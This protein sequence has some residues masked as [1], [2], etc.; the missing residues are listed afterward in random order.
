MNNGFVPPSLAQHFEA[1]DNYLGHF[2]WICGYSAD[3]EFLNDAAERFTRQINAQRAFDGNISLVLLLDGGNPK[4]EI[5]DVP[6]VLHLAMKTPPTE[7]PFKL[8]HAKV[9]VLGFRHKSDKERWLLRLIVSTGNWTR[10]TLEESLDLAWCLNLDSTDLKNVNDKVLLACSDIVAAWDM[11][12]SVQKHFDLRLL[13]NWPEEHGKFLSGQSNNRFEAWITQISKIVKKEGS[14]PIPRFF[15]NRKKSLLDQ[16]PNMIDNTGNN[17]P[18]NYLAMGSGFYESSSPQQKPP[19]VISAIVSKLKEESA[20]RRLLTAGAEIDIFVNP[21]ACQGVS[22][23]LEAIQSNKWV[24]RAAAQPNYFGKNATRFLHAKFIFSA[25]N[26]QNAAQSSW[27]YLG[28]GN[29]TKQ[30]FTRKMSNSGGNLEAGV[31]FA[32]GKL[33]WKGTDIDPK[34]ILG[35]VIPVQR[36]SKIEGDNAL[37]AGGEMPEHETQFVVPPVAYFF[38]YENEGNQCSYLKYLVDDCLTDFNVIDESGAICPKIVDTEG[39]FFWLGEQPRQVRVCWDE[40]GQTL[41]SMVPVLDKFGRVAATTLPQ[42]D[43]DNVWWQL[44]DFPSPPEMDD[45]TDEDELNGG[46]NGENEQEIHHAKQVRYPVRQMM[47]LI[48]NIAAKQTTLSQTDWAAWC[49]R[50]EQS[51]MQAADT[52]AI[53]EFSKF[54]INPLSPLWHEPFRPHF[55]ETNQTPDGQA[56][57]SMLLRVEQKWK[58]KEFN[59]LGDL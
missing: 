27:L 52:P 26:R 15:D 12:T 11:L 21:N 40:N 4:I 28:S 3:A 41:E 13:K 47:Q 31:V 53:K 29:L 54:E 32:P 14:R 58:V 17:N 55:A 10:Q 49:V 16:L 44:A 30:G 8:L 5:T 24:V 37:S 43:L 51:L 42:I 57:E 45:E 23:S 33:Y 48:E 35:N 1:P 34:E 39:G 36:D 19:E 22:Q 2:G 56:Y 20:S 59:K 46:R 6:G 9:A 7:R 18:H 25:S 50:L 38:W